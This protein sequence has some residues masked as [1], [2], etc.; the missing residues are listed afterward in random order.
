MLSDRFAS[1]GPKWIVISDGNFHWI[2]NEQ[3]MSAHPWKHEAHA[4]WKHKNGGWKKKNPAE[5]PG[6]WRGKD[7]GHERHICGY[8]KFLSTLFKCTLTCEFPGLS[9]VSRAS[10]QQECETIV[11]L[12]GNKNGGATYYSFVATPDFCRAF[13][14]VVWWISL[15]KIAISCINMHHLLRFSCL[16]L[17]SVFSNW[18]IWS[19]FFHL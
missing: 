3:E 8:F 10:R 7:V 12:V 17:W 15:G 4:P 6:H 9:L 18:K 1:S 14:T 19:F 5:M 16:R 13:C 2:P 11:S